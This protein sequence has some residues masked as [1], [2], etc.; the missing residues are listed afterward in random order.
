VG[1]WGNYAKLVEEKSA[2][3]VRVLWGSGVGGGLTCGFWAVF[4]GD[5]GDLFLVARAVEKAQG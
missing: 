2:V 5:F 1:W 3:V 4:G